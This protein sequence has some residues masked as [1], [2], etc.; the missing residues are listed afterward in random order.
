MLG[1][2]LWIC[3]NKFF[4]KNAFIEIWKTRKAACEDYKESKHSSTNASKHASLYLIIM[5]RMDN[6]A[7]VQSSE[8]VMYAASSTAP[9]DAVLP[10]RNIDAMIFEVV[11]YIFHRRQSTSVTI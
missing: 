6:G 4:K 3:S 7:D 8:T 2:R 9:A 5:Y 10:D 11:D 1:R